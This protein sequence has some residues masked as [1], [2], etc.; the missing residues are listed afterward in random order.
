MK[1][2]ALMRHGSTP[3]EMTTNKALPSHPHIIDLK[4]YN[5]ILCTLFHIDGEERASLRPL[6][7]VKQ[8]V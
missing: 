2:L 3:A 8:A 4:L 5:Y 1:A 7:Y 6:C